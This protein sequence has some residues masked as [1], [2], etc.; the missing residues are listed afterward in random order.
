M[1]RIRYKK[2]RYTI[3]VI[4]N[5]DKLSV[6]VDGVERTLY[7]R[8]QGYTGSVSYVVYVPEKGHNKQ[9]TIAKSIVEAVKEG[10]S[11]G[12]E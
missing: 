2:D 11:N 7:T 12:D 9:L 8:L 10:I 4:W 6:I 5:G 3:D 1:S